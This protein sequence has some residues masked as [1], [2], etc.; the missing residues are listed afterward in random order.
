MK[1]TSALPLFMFFII[2]CSNN[3]TKHMGEQS[4]KIEAEKFLENY[5][6]QFQQLLIVASEA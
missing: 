1:I 2:S 3:E 6:T 5:N 4:V